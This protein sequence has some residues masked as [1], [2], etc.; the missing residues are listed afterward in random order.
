MPDLDA[1]PEDWTRALAVVAH[2]DDLEYG[3]ASAIARWTGQGKEVAYCLVTSGEAGID[4]MPPDECA[5]VR[6]AEERAS[7]AAVGVET[8]EFLHHPD[9]LVEASLVLRR[10]LAAAIRRH[11]PEV[12]ISI[13]F[14]ETFGFPGLNHAD[15]R[16][17]GIALLDAVRDAANRWVFVGAGGEP[18][19]GV[20]F[21][22]FGGSPQ[23]THAV[24]ITATLD[25]GVASLEAHRTYLDALAA[26]TTGTNPDEFLRGMAEQAG[27]RL[28]VDL[29]TTFELIPLG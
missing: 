16:N 24:D 18:W 23:A 6:Q 1:V 26:G 27:P 5:V 19:D 10:D 15:H 7:A 11:R 14:R 20:R 29:A 21:A 13:N 4:S 28:G 17:T 25:R 9:G 12:V 2:P 3:A 22:V 8:V